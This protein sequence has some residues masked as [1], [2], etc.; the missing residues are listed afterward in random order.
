MH[1]H[2]GL[3]TFYMAM[4]DILLLLQSMMTTLRTPLHLYRHQNTSQFYRIWGT[5]TRPQYLLN[6]ILANSDISTTH[7]YD[8]IT[9]TSRMNLSKCLVILHDILGILSGSQKSTDNIR[10]LTDVTNLTSCIS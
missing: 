3:L 7:Y 6:R 10:R 9:K 2:D 8:S 4:C 1:V 5:G